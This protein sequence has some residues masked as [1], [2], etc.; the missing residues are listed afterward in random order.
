MYFKEWLLTESEEK[1]VVGAGSDCPVCGKPAVDWCRCQ[2]SDTYCENKHSWH[3]C[4][5]HKK[6]AVGSGHGKQGCTCQ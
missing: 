3:R 4:M 5:V 1:P 6:M 2:M